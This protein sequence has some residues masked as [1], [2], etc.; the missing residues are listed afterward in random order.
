[1]L[2]DAREG[3]G[4]DRVDVTVLT[5]IKEANLTNVELGRGSASVTFR[6]YVEFLGSRLGPKW[7]EQ[8]RDAALSDAT[9]HMTRSSNPV[10]QAVVAYKQMWGARPKRDRR[11]APRRSRESW[12][13]IL[14][15][16]R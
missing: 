9:G 11:T 4:L 7:V 13:D 6:A 10:D 1:M 14:A 16:V 5:G 3:L 15:G 12:E 8:V 2:Y